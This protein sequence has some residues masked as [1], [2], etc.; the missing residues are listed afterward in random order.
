MDFVIN[1]RCISSLISSI[2]AEISSTSVA[3]EPS[4]L[5]ITCRT[6]FT[7]TCLK[8]ILNCSHKFF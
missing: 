6:C 2:I 7:V 1:E 5:K 3:L 4:I 8:E